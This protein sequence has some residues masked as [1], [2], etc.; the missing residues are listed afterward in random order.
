MDDSHVRSF[1]RYTRHQLKYYDEYHIEVLYTMD[2]DKVKCLLNYGKTKE[3]II[4]K[5]RYMTYGDVWALEPEDFEMYTGTF[6]PSAEILILKTYTNEQFEHVKVLHDIQPNLSY[7][8]HQCLARRFYE[9]EDFELAWK[10]K[11]DEIVDENLERSKKT[12]LDKKWELRT[13]KQKRFLMKHVMPSDMY[14]Q[15]I[16]DVITDHLY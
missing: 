15:D 16:H 12:F 11:W 1:L 9:D 6:S 7:I 4:P 13:K 8:K 2:C 14:L 5:I 3:E 10:K